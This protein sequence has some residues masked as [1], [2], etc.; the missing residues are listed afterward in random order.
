MGG[1]DDPNKLLLSKLFWASLL[2]IPIGSNVAIV[3]VVVVVVVVGVGV[4]VGVGVV[5]V[6]VVVAVVK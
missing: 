2:L 3:V 6:G 5:V 1:G 4:G